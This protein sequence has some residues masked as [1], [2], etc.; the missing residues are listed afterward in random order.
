MGESPSRDESDRPFPGS[1][2]ESD[3]EGEDQGLGGLYR[4][5]EAS[6]GPSPV[7]PMETPYLQLE[8]RPGAEPG[9]RPGA[10]PGPRPGAWPGASNIIPLGRGLAR[11]SGRAPDRVPQPGA[12]PGS[13]RDPDDRGREA[14]QPEPR[15]SPPPRPGARPGSNRVPDNR[16]QEAQPEQPEPPWLQPPRPGPCPDTYTPGPGWHTYRPPYPDPYGPGAFWLDQAPFG[17]QWQ[18]PFRP[19][20]YASGMYAPVP[21]Y[22]LESTRAF[23]SAPRENQLQDTQVK[24][25]VPVFIPVV[26]NPTSVP[27]SAPGAMSGNS[28][29][30]LTRDLSASDLTDIDRKSTRLNSS[31]VE[32]S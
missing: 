13:N 15:W 4:E 32:I 31:H 12:R 10:W 24:S 1:P 14:L 22:N 26:S 18:G 30:D 11:G 7:P 5:P 2:D 29:R 6:P 3:T 28:S 21:R 23:Y 9:P 27:L 19:D 17:P 20:P 8:A 25:S 16:V